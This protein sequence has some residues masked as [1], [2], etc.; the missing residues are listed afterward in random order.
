VSSIAAFDGCRSLYGRG[1]LAVESAV[2][3]AGGVRVRPGL[4]YGDS[5]GRGMVGS[6]AKAAKLPIVPVFGDG[7]QPFYLAHVDDVTQVLADAADGR[8]EWG[9]TPVDRGESVSYHFLGFAD[10]P[11]C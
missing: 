9:G 3:Q 2:L 4:V 5:Q 8:E 7:T 10:G 1:K 6:L 11:C